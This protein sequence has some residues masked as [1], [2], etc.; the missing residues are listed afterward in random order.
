MTPQEQEFRELFDSITV[1]V[2]GSTT[3]HAISFDGF[4]VIA[5][6]LLQLGYQRGFSRATEIAHSTIEE[7]LNY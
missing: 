1:Q 6:R 2:P 4:K 5:E 7:V 3:I